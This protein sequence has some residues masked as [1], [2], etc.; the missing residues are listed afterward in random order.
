MPRSVTAAVAAAF[1]LTITTPAL[2]AQFTVN[3][4]TDAVDATPG[5]GVC[6]TAAGAC[7]LRAAIQE[8]NALAGSDAV[9]LPAGQFALTRGGDDETAVAGDLDITG[10]TTIAGAG[11]RNTV[12]DAQ[13]IDRIFDVKAGTTVAISGVT[14][15]RGHA[16]DGGGIENGGALTLTGV[17]LI[18]NEA[19]F[20]S[21]SLGDG[22]GIENTGA[23]TLAITDSLLAY[24]TGYNGGAVDSGKPI[25]TNTTVY[26]NTAGYYGDNGDGG[27]FDGSGPITLI[28]STV[29]GNAA[30]NGLGAG[31]GIDGA[32]ILKNSIVTDNVSYN[33]STPGPGE[34]D[35]C[36]GSV[37]S[38]GNNMEN[39]STCGLSGPGDRN[40]DPM[41]APLAPNGGPTDTMALRAGSPAIDAGS[42]SGCPAA[43]QRGVPRPGGGACD[44]GAYEV[45]PPA[46]TTGPSSA[47]TTDAAQLAGAVNAAGSRTTYHFDFGTTDAYGS[48]TPSAAAGA[49]VGDVV[50]SATLAGLSPGTTYHYRLVAANP[51]GTATGADQTF[52]TAAV[53]VPATQPQDRTAPGLTL[54]KLKK[55]I[56]LKAFLKG[57]KIV[58]SP[59][60]AVKLTFELRA[61]GRKATLAKAYNVVLGTKSLKLAAGKRSA[62]LKPSKTLVGRPRKFT[63]EVIV[64][65]TDAAG[66][67]TVKK[68]TFTVKR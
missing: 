5:N 33:A 66:N 16:G 40:T 60:E 36:S 43:D 51:D 1:V 2:A 45:A 35:N 6:A 39:G 24:N 58:A 62:T 44:I 48:S 22:G 50:A 46:A 11:A 12:I 23:S 21:G 14:I 59:N 64:T 3:S 15:T 67:Q 63:V 57:V 37:T 61:S 55:S 47:V 28:N 29:A 32:S 38:Q 4:T 31:G 42:N 27:A 65:A 7:T 17:A 9:T 54:G 53:V 34:A 56:K 68:A 19:S 25:L 18:A 10:N 20:S 26:G 30:Y 49:G 13:R 41:L 52:T 8:A